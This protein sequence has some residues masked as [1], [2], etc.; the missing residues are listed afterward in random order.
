M[1]GLLVSKDLELR[2]L[3]LERDLRG[4]VDAVWRSWT[5][6]AEL[7]A[8]WGPEGWATT[9]RSLD[10][11]PGGLWHFGMGRTGEPPEVWIRSIYTEVITG[12]ALSYVEGFS[13]DT[14]ADLDPES[15]AVTVEFI[16]MEP[17]R[18]RLVMRT[19]FTSVDRLERILAMGVVEGWT[20]AF[21][22]LDDRLRSTT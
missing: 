2:E 6:A 22:R 5:S 14:G 12:S 8:W 15:Q 7:E 10:V 16:G 20:G 13:D 9:V 4:S 17:G 1:S 3:V 19:R 21:D 11:R 18:T